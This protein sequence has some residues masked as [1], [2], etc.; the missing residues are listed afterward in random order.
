MGQDPGKSSTKLVPIPCSEEEREQYRKQQ[1]VADAER[2]RQAQEEFERTGG[3]VHPTSVFGFTTSPGLTI[4]D[5]FATA[6]LGPLVTLGI[7]QGTKTN[8]WILADDA[9]QHAYEIADAMLRA[10]K[11]VKS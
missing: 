11:A 9:A 6:A 10:R 1:E 8:R 7:Q 2:R 5:H 3:S 4:R